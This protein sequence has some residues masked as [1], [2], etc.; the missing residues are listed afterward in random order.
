MVKPGTPELSL[1]D[2]LFDRAADPNTIR[3]F[4]NSKSGSLARSKRESSRDNSGVPVRRSRA[5]NMMDESDA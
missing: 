5:N 3:K 4:A 1:D 2:S